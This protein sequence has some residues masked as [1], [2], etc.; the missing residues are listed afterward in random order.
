MILGMRVRGVLFATLI[1][2]AAPVAAPLAAML[3]S[4]PAAAQG[5]SSIAVEGN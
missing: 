4:A 3:V 2:F 5:V 1:M